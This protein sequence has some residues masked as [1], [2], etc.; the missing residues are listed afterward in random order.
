MNFNFSKEKQLD[1]AMNRSV[2]YAK[3]QYNSVKKYM[4]SLGVEKPIHIGETGWATFSNEL[5]G[6]NDSKAVDEYKAGI[7]YHK[8]RDWTNEAG[9]SV[10]IL[11]RLMNLGKMLE[12]QAVRKIISDCLPSTEM[13]NMRFG[14][15]WMKALLK[16]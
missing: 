11:K 8:M 15:W 14:I 6:S 5:Y 7:F 13:Q 12:I 16:N 4:Q 10:S 2:N 3:S 9:I 1:L